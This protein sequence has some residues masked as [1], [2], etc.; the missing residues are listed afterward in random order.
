MAESHDAVK[1]KDVA[2]SHVA[3]GVGAVIVF[4]VAFVLLCCARQ[5]ARKDA[6]TPA[7]AESKG[8]VAVVP[9]YVTSA[10]A[11]A[12]AAEISADVEG[13]TRGT[14]ES[15]PV[16]GQPL[17]QACEHH[18]TSAGSLL[19]QVTLTLALPLTLT[20]TITLTR[21]LA[22]TQAAPRA[23]ARVVALSW[24]SETEISEIDLAM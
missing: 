4:I 3:I 8:R 11:D 24:L 9:A 21:T 23:G 5:W 1:Q 12:D 2:V 17:V 19:G 10:K 22:L 6:E 20:L 7:A 18:T 13:E 16:V 14:N 15:Q